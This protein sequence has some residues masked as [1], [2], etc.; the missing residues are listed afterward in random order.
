MKEKIVIGQIGVGQWGVNL[1]RNFSALPNCSVKFAS[2][3][4]PAQR[5]KLSKEYPQTGFV[6]DYNQILQDPEIDGVV[7]ATPASEH[8]QVA[9]QALTSG[10]H[11]FVEKPITLDI[12]QAADLVALAKKIN[13][14][15]MVGHLLLYHPATR[16]LKE[17]IDQGE[18]GEIRYV[19]TQRLNLG[20]IRNTEN[21][22][23]SL[24]PHDISIVLHLLGKQPIAVSALGSDFIQKGI[25]DVAFINIRFQNGEIGHIHVSWLDPTK[26]RRTIVVGSKKMAIFDEMKARN[27]LTLI[28]KGVDITKDFQSYKEF[29]SLRFGEETVVSV[30]PAEP[31]KLECE[32]FIECILTGRK[33]ISDGQ[34]GLDVLK[35]LSTAEA[36]LKKGG[37]NEL[38]CA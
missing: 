23:W 1:L 17:L 25:E 8:Y 34:N 27:A 5:D 32:H 26:T 9:K 4:N 15:I 7:I 28:D 12:K 29:L 37:A 16:K 24:A 31:L 10:K 21:V 13:K 20:R 2:D 35:I 22:M 19:Y 6:A 36:S 18:L 38:L 3:L 33:P 30:D 14:Q 11:V